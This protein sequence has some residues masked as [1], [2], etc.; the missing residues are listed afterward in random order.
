[1]LGNL[2]QPLW[3]WSDP[4]AIHFLDFWRAL[5]PNVTFILVY[6]EPGASLI[7]NGHERDG[8]TA[9][10]VRLRLKAW[11][12]FNAELLRFFNRNTERCLLVHSRV[13]CLRARPPMEQLCARIEASPAVWVGLHRDQSISPPPGVPEAEEVNASRPTK[14]PLQKYLV[15]A[16]LYHFPQAEQ[17]YEELQAVA[18][19][20]SAD[21]E[22][23]TRVDQHWTTSAEQSCK[24][25]DRVFSA[26]QSM[27]ALKQISKRW[28]AGQKDLEERLREV[29]A[30]SREEEGRATRLQHELRR[31]QEEAKRRV[32]SLEGARTWLEVA[33]RESEA[34]TDRMRAKLEG[35][36]MELRRLEAQVLEQRG[37]LES[38]HSASALAAE[39]RAQ[40]EELQRKLAA[41]EQIVREAEKKREEKNSSVRHLE[42]ENKVLLEQLHQVQEDLERYYV[43]SQARKGTT[44]ARTES[45]E[46]RIVHHG[47]ADRLKGY[48][49]YRLGAIMVQRGRSVAGWAGMPIALFREFRKF[50]KELPI[51]RAKKLPPISRYADAAEAD[52]VKRH[53][54]YRLGSTIISHARNP[55]L[56][57]VLPWALFQQVRSF[58]RSRQV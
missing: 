39:R 20:P 52:R 6:D 54:S 21:D 48:L 33:R 30:R 46:Q 40:V 28:E 4:W 16:I 12:E 43:E 50:R 19:L 34:E 31:S 32:A 14:D 1:M 58:R 24:A 41:Q 5:D 49:S 25:E 37:E 56:W 57:L 18:T 10:Q 2:D 13:G 7:S 44:L 17:I 35:A 22:S 38:L 9:E 47:A 23:S 3:G 45:A 29:E 51:R 55:L 8:G 42:E 53:L 36:D 15:E 26:W 11:C 27:V